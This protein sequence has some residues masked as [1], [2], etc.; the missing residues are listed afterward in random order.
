LTWAVAD[1]DAKVAESIAEPRFTMTILVLFAV[2]GVLL[3]AVGLFGVVSY[4]LAVRTR[5]IGVRITLGATRR[6]IAG[7]FVRDALAQA[8]LGTAIG[9]A[10]AVIVERLAQ[11]SFYGVGRFDATT[12]VLAAAAMLLASAAACAGPLFRAIRVDPAAAIRAE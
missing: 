12:F 2:S 4:S 5:E 6:N 7:L 11:M 8:A 3:A 10:G 9:L 1:V